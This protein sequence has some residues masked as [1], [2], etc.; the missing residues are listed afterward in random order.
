LEAFA[1]GA[2]L[3]AITA[4]P[5]TSTIAA[6]EASHPLCHQRRRERMD[7]VA[8][9]AR[10]AVHTS[11]GGAMSRGSACAAPTS[12][13]TRCSIA[14]QSAHSAMCRDSGRSAS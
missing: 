7:S 4:V 8:T 6:A 14:R 1:L 11:T 5:T 10:S 12:S 13:R 2:A 3:V 9:R